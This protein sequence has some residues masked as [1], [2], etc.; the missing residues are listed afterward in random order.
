MSVELSINDRISPAMRR[1]LAA[2]QDKRP[3]LEAGGEV[4]ASH[5]TRA[6]RQDSLRPAPWD[7]LAAS[8]LKRKGRD[9][10]LLIDTGMLFASLSGA[11]PAVWEV[12]SEQIEVGTDREYA[13]FHQFGTKKMPARPFFPVDG[14][15]EL[16][17]AAARELKATLEAA[18][19]ARI[20]AS[21][22]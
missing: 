19:G 11:Q 8:T 3:V 5:A 10:G 12:G 2:M 6:F 9:S 21:T 16:T 20:G 18:I 14:G 13:V 17:A 4:L 22:R 1:A 15:G 7:P